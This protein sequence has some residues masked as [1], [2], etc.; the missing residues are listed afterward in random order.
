MGIE[1]SDLDGATAR[2]LA[3][4]GGAVVNALKDSG[5]AANAG[6]VVR[7]VIVAV[8]GRS[9]DSMNALVVALRSHRPGDVTTVEVM[10]DDQRMT[11]AVALA[12]RPP[13]P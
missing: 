13:N 6:L 4:D 7:D 10:H 12:E 2:D 1:G 9:V 5:P 11:R 8:D 3:V